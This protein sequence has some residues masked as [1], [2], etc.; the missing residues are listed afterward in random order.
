MTT[1]VCRARKSKS[2]YHGRDEIAIYG[3]GG[4]A[5]DGLFNGQSVVCDACYIGGGQPSLYCGANP[6]EEDIINHAQSG[7][8]PNVHVDQQMGLGEYQ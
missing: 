4:M 2:C 7:G 6:T 5:N 1:I 8:D 3:Q